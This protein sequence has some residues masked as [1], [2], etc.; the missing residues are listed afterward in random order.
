MPADFAARLW[1]PLL[2]DLSLKSLPLFLLAGLA[3]LLLRRASASARHL[4]WLLL[5]GSLLC[6]PLCSALLPRWSLP[7]LTPRGSQP[8]FAPTPPIPSTPAP[9]ASAPNAAPESASPQSTAPVF[10]A[11]PAPLAAAAP[12]RPLWPQRLLL[13]WLVGLVLVAAPILAGLARLGSLRRSG[14]PVSEG[15]VSE[16]ALALARELGVLR[17]VFLLH[18]SDD[19]ARMPMTWG[20]ARP[21]ILLP[22]GASD[23][24]VDRLRAVLLHE[25]A[26]I[27][28]GD[29]PCQMLAHLACA[30]YWFHPLVWLAARQ[31]RLESER[32]CDDLVLTAGVAPSDYAR[33]LLEVV[34]SLKHVHLTVPVALPMAQSSRVEGRIRA[35]LEK[36]KRTMITKRMLWLGLA[37]ATVVLLPL[38]ALE[39]RHTENNAPNAAL[40]ATPPEMAWHRALPKT[41]I[42]ASDWKAALPG[43]LV[44]SLVGVSQNPS[45]GKAWW[46]PDGSA[47]SSAPYASASEESRS[48]DMQSKEFALRLTGLPAAQVSLA[49]QSLGAGN[50]NITSFRSRNDRPVGRGLQAVV[51]SFPKTQE[52]GGFLL[53][54]ADGPWKTM[55]A[56]TFGPNNSVGTP[57]W[58]GDAVV[59]ISTGRDADRPLIASVADDTQG[60]ETR[61]VAVDWKGGVHAS[62]MEDSGGSATTAFSGV[63]SV[64]EAIRSYHNIHQSLVAFPGLLLRNAREVQFQTRPYRWVQ[65]QDIA[66]RPKG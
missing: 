48:A 19:A 25:L 4:V 62:N 63:H 24:P 2:R 32:A 35:I 33:H 52:R 37:T 43:G 47:L 26:H 65:F 13:L 18:A 23:W 14:A 64:D 31:M 38:A 54:L 6:L 16:M 61:I 30:L 57:V 39:S 59:L 50:C 10:L 1:L 9:P 29:W 55:V 36:R 60:V 15:P 12:T 41:I 58:S 27:R 42:A 34:R 66:L 20:W 51:A 21:V 40:A 44:V 49:A 7:V 45:R 8:V 11:I 46:K 28:R 17:P 5:L 56:K 22:A 3:A 53:G